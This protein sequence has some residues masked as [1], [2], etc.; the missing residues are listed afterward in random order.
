VG[1][2]AGLDSV[3]KRKF[4]TLSGLEIRSL[5][6]PVTTIVWSKNYKTLR[7]PVCNS[8]HLHP[9]SVVQIYS[10]VPFSHGARGSVVG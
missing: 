6:R 1:P 5:G 3:E 4:L 2:R 7:C 10:S 8:I 9:L